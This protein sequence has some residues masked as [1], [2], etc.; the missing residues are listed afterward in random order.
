MNSPS[1]SE[2][3]HQ[4]LASPLTEDDLP[5]VEIAKGHS[6]FAWGD[7]LRIPHRGRPEGRIPLAGCWGHIPQQPHTGADGWE[8]PPLPTMPQACLPYH[9]GG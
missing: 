8:R 4:S 6:L 9:L 1:I 2:I 3:P 7:C 5:S